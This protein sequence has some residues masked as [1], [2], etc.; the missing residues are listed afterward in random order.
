M[1]RI[2]TIAIII[3]GIQFSLS[4]QTKICKEDFTPVCDSLAVLISEHTGVEGK[5]KLE[6]T[7]SKKQPSTRMQ[8]VLDFLNQTP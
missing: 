8:K 4:A 3:F 6:L 5:L 7:K 1:K 2:S